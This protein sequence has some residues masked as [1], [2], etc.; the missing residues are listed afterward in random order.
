MSREHGSSWTQCR[1]EADCNH[2]GSPW[3][4][5]VRELGDPTG[6]LRRSLRGL[7]LPRCCDCVSAARAD[8]RWFRHGP[9]APLGADRQWTRWSG[10][11]RRVAVREDAVMGSA[12]NGG[13]GSGAR[14]RDGLRLANG[15]A[16]REQL[17][18]LRGPST[19]P[20]PPTPPCRSRS[21]LR[22]AA[23]VAPE[24]LDCGPPST[25]AAARAWRY[26]AERSTA[27]TSTSPRAPR[28]Q[29]RSTKR[30]QPR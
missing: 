18:S 26:R 10:G 4:A 1:T 6:R 14:R 5:L 20:P 24:W 9:H 13:G 30:I 29:D 23:P 17:R 22:A 3:H 11:G 27:P 16:R 19:G 25:R 8:G 28:R 12:R 7:R 21:C 2:G 15:I